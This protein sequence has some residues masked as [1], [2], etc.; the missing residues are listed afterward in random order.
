MLETMSLTLR[1]DP[2]SRTG[3]FRAPNRDHERPVVPPSDRSVR[4]TSHVIGQGALCA[5]DDLHPGHYSYT[6]YIFTEA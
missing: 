2:D 1:R 5:S 6:Y 3:N 4:T